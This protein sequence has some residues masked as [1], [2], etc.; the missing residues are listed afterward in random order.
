MIYDC[1]DN[2][3]LVLGLFLDLKKPLILSITKYYSKNC[4]IME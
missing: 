1:L 4:I 3:L 2:N